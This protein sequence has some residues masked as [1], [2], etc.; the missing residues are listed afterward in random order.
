MTRVWNTEVFIG[1]WYGSWLFGMLERNGLT[2]EWSLHR[3]ERG[4]QGSFVRKHK[5]PAM[6]V[7][8][9][10]RNPENVRGQAGTMQGGEV[11]RFLKMVFPGI[12]LDVCGWF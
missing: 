3:M 2:C 6:E 11:E 12:S 4:K 8:R 7:V 9:G 1:G 10:K 5:R